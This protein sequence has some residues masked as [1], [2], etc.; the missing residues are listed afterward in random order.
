MSL[1]K[2]SLNHLHQQLDGRMVDFAGWEMP[3][4]YGSTLR[5]HLAV[6]ESVGIFDVSHMGE[7]EMLGKDALSMAQKVTSNDVSRLQDGQAHYSA[8]LYPKGTFVDDIVLYRINSEHI[9]IC[10][11]A[12]NREKD[13]QWV[14]QHREGEVEILDRGDAYAQ[15]AIQGP[16][17]EAVLQKLTNVDLSAIRTYWF[18]R[19]KVDG[20]ASLI[21]RT[22]YTGEDGFEIYIPPKA[23]PAIWEKLLSVGK[24]LGITPAGLAARNTL[25]LEMAYSL[26]GHEI[27][28][29]TNPWEANLAWIVKLEKGE[30]IGQAALERLKK[31]GPDRRLVGFEM[32]DRGIARDHYSVWVDGE[33]VSEVT[34][35]SPAPSLGKHVGLTYLPIRYTE[36]EQ[37]LEVEVRGKRLK[38]KVVSTPFLK[39]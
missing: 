6:R 9:F 21:S 7:I 38:A 24:P 25:R 14:H 30:F 16:Q 23:A 15:L 13:F 18:S 39:K 33:K 22:G 20:A 5:E 32:V 19:G 4:D 17:A 1:K 11:N 27:D 26:Y 3:V 31:A 36:V 35:G 12:A 8:F 10:V 37:L 28:Q 34:S 29:T 2:T